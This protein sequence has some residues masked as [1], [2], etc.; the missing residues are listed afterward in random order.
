MNTWRIRLAAGLA[1]LVRNRQSRRA[2]HQRQGCVQPG[3]AGFRLLP[4]GAVHGRRLVEE[5]LRAQGAGP[6]WRINVLLT[7]LI[8]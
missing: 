2:V 1:S 5:I 7:L 6:V 8:F 4:G 3:L